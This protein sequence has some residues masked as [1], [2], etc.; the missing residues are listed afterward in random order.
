MTDVMVMLSVLFMGQCNHGGGSNDHKT[1]Q[2][3][4]YSSQPA[5]RPAPMILHIDG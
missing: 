4:Q 2:H 1:M 5:G 3:D